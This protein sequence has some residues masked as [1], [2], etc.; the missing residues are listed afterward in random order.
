MYYRYYV[1]SEEVSMIL[2]LRPF[3]YFLLPLL[4]GRSVISCM[5]SNTLYAL[6]MVWYAYIT[7]LG[8]RGELNYLFL[9]S[10]TLESCVI[11]L[12]FLNNTQVFYWYPLVIVAFLWLFSITLIFLG[13]RLNVTRIV[14][15][16]HFG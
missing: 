7:H 13:L 9:K 14:M 6:A 1:A 15:A 2:T 11:A 10:C 16:F 4:L 12:P 5:A 8:Y 3:Q